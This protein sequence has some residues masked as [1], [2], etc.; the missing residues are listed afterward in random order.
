MMQKE[1]YNLPRAFESSGSANANN[2]NNIVLYF[3]G[4]ISER[5]KKLE[6]VGDGKLKKGRGNNQ[7]RLKP[8]KELFRSKDDLDYRRSTYAT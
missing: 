2:L 8:E 3:K 4:S 1:K 5:E 7:K 6:W